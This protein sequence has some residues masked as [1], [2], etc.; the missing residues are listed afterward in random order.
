MN[1][2]DYRA[3]RDEQVIRKELNKPK[4][5]KESHTSNYSYTATQSSKTLITTKE[6]A[7]KDTLLSYKRL[8]N[9]HLELNEMINH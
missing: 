3:Y 2:S 1:A 4:A 8:N 9:K 5:T 6:Q 7:I